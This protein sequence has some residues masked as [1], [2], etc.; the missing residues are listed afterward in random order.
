MK[1]YLDKLLRLGFC[2]STAIG[3]STSVVPL[4]IFGNNYWVY[5]TFCL[6]RGI[7][8][9]RR[10]H[11]WV[12][13]FARKLQTA[14][15]S[16]SRY[17]IDNRRTCKRS[18]V[19]MKSFIT[20]L[21]GA[22]AVFG[23]ILLL[24]NIFVYFFVILYDCLLCFPFYFSLKK[25]Y[26]T[27]LWKVGLQINELYHNNEPC[28]KIKSQERMSPLYNRIKCIRSSF[29]GIQLIFIYSLI[30]NSISKLRSR[31]A[32]SWI[33]NHRIV[34]LKRRESWNLWPSC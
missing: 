19:D 14:T 31:Q 2:L 5:T 21:R 1:T 20:I 8:V 22:S 3:H 11:E 24:L 4:L 12:P 32:K 27:A 15:P 23:L 13:T 30:F 10:I 17:F 29:S 9:S 6:P 18:S 34:L 16:K 7:S 26:L 33:D 28:K 25:V